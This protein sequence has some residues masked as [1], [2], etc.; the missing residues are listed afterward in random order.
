M[1]RPA[2]RPNKALGQHFLHDAVVLGRIAALAAPAPGSG[3]VEIGPGTGNLTAHLIELLPRL[4]GQPLPLTLVELDARA[5]E[6]LCTRFA[7]LAAADGRP[8]CRIE[9]A[10]AVTVD[11]PALLRDPAL[12]PQPVVV[13]NLPY[14]AAMPIL[15]SLLDLPTPPMRL[16]FMVQRE[17]ADRLVAG[18]SHPDCGQ[19][20]VKVQLRAAVR[21]ALKVGRGAFQPPPNVESAVVVIEPFAAPVF[22]MP[23]WPMMARIVAAGFAARRKTLAN[24]LQIGGFAERAVRAALVAAQVDGRVRAEALTLAQWASLGRSLA[25]GA[26]QADVG[27]G[28][29]QTA[30]AR[31]PAD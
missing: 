7:A 22:A 27:N 8:F 19:I 29:A 25:G 14:N 1:T 28:A 10:D 30:L 20:S 3:L 24:A 18:P 23:P 31:L 4:P 2:L 26:N 21:L 11:W 16:V 9:L 12:G 15:F 13:G 6:A 5:P 17:V